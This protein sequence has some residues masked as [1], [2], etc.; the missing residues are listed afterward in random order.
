MQLAPVVD[1]ANTGGRRK[2]RGS[3]YFTVALL[4]LISAVGFLM[5]PRSDNLVDN[6]MSNLKHFD[7]GAIM[8]MMP[9]FTPNMPNVPVPHHEFNSPIKNKIEMKRKR[10]RARKSG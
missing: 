10:A 5:V 2:P 9:G 6:I 4:P 8:R 1:V 7:F 3:V